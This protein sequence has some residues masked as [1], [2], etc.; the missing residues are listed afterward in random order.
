M[1]GMLVSCHL[2]IVSPGL[3]ACGSTATAAASASRARHWW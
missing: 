3:A 1:S 2:M